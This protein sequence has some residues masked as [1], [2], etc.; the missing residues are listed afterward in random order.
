M[1]WHFANSQNLFGCDMYD[2][3]MVELPL[4]FYD[5]FSLNTKAQ[6]DTIFLLIGVPFLCWRFYSFKITLHD[7]SA[8]MNSHVNERVQGVTEKLKPNLKSTT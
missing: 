8:S 4:F 2:L 5:I 6:L 1:W 3:T 7:S